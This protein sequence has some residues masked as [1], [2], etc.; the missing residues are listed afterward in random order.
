MNWISNEKD[1]QEYFEAVISK[2]T[3]EFE[4]EKV[5]SGIKNVGSALQGH[6]SEKLSMHGFQSAFEVSNQA[7]QL[8]QN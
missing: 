1:V 4:T 5:S 7:R 2:M 8:V 3:K 6:H